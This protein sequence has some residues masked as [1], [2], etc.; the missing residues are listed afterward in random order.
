VELAGTIRTFEKSVQDAI[1]TRM[2]EI[3]AG[4]TKASRAEFTLEFD[5]SHPV[6]INDSMLT[7]R[8][9]PTLERLLGAGSVRHRPPITGAEDFSYFANEVPGF[10]FFLGAVPPNKKSGG[11]HTPTF[12]ADD[13][14]VPVGIRV[15]TGLVLEFL[16]S[17]AKL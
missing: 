17:G 3:F 9:A 16:N 7:A 6:T 15:M 5:R 13:R 4:I 2:R 14:A 8:R 10:F 1:E 12:Y 11:H